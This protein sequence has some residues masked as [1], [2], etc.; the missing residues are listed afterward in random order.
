M[1]GEKRWWQALQPCR[2]RQDEIGVRADQSADEWDARMSAPWAQ[3][4]VLFCSMQYPQHLEEILVY[5]GCSLISA[6]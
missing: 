3:V 4:L 6:E 2:G 5:S 1:E